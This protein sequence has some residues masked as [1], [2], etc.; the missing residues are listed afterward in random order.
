MRRTQELDEEGANMHIVAAEVSIYRDIS[1]NEI[2][3][4]TGTVKC[5]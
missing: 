2:H 4:T 5:C 1:E 3:V